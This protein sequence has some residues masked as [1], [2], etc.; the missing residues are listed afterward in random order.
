[1]PAPEAARTSARPMA[2]ETPLV[3]VSTR[4]P[5]AQPRN[6]R[7]PLGFMVPI[8]LAPRSPSPRPRCRS[9]SGLSAP[10][11]HFGGDGFGHGALRRERVRAHAQ[12]LGLGGRWN[13]GDKAAVDHDRTSRAHRSS[14]G[15]DHAPR[16]A[17][18]GGDGSSPGGAAPRA[19]LGRRH[20]ITCGRCARK[21]RTATTK[22][23]QPA[24]RSRR[25][26][27]T[28]EGAPAGGSA[29]PTGA[30]FQHVEE[31]RKAE[32][33]GQHTSAR[34]AQQEIGPGQFNICAPQRH[35]ARARSTGPR[36]S[37]IH[38]FRGVLVGACPSWPRPR[39]T[40]P[41]AVTASVA[42]E[43]QPEPPRQMQC[44]GQRG[45]PAALPHVPGAGRRWPTKKTVMM[46][47]IMISPA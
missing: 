40:S 25:P 36:T 14:G 39:P 37:S 26:A 15:R 13:K 30:G 34:C 2:P 43:Q 31:L 28:P 23:G 44:P 29:Q 22:R 21:A 45:S 7:G 33:S 17:F 11:G 32:E 24:R 3:S 12:H 38:D 47:R 4:P 16:A 8:R 42:A 19:H 5:W 6:R 41:A 10:I 20:S 35:R 1:M 27:M 9:P 46:A 18:G